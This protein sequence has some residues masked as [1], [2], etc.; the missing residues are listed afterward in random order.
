[1]SSLFVLS[2]ALRLRSFAPPALSRAQGEVG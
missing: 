1:M 2:N